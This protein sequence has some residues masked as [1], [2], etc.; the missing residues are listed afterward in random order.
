MPP[1]LSSLLQGLVPGSRLAAVAAAPRP[2]RAEAAPLGGRATLGAPTAA[3][4]IGG[5][6]EVRVD[7]AARRQA[8]EG[9]GTSL[10]WWANVVGEWGEIRV[11]E[12]GT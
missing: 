11:A 3:A 6:A 2:A 5:D 1:F 7:A 4:G 8:F 9:W 10:A 12:G